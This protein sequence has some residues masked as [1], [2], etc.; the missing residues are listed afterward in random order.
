MERPDLRALPCDRLTAFMAALGLPPAAAPRVFVALQRTGVDGFA[1]MGVKREI[2]DILAERSFISRLMPF[3]L[4]TSEDGTRKFVFRLPDGALI[5]SV[6]IPEG[7]RHTLCLSS[8][9]GCAM[10]C[11]FCLTGCM[12]FVRNL[13]PAEIVNQVLAVIGWMRANGIRRPTP[14]EY[15]NNLV[16]M[17]MGE[18]LANYESVRDA[19]LIL[20]DWRGLEFTERRVTVSTCGLVP[21]IAALG[22]DLRV[23]L[24]VSLHAADDET[25]SRLMPVNRTYPL[26]RLLA[27][28]RTYPLAKKRVI[29]IEYILIAAVNDRETD[30]HQL[31]DRLRGIPCRINLLPCNPANELPFQRPEAERVAR[32]AQVLRQAG[33]TTIIRASRG[34]DIAAA[35]GQLVGTIDSLSV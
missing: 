17:G 25:R 27:A 22:R 2:R 23:N 32:F 33:Y 15:V 7:K 12:G 18:P 30:A 35:C 3:A 10:G 9:A 20:M 19:L 21:G 13:T 6:L 4:E 5:E 31:A 8:Q 16:L 28:L 24:A 11:A 26:E 1:D 29:L 14:R 34:A